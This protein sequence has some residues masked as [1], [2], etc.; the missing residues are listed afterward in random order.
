MR[1]GMTVDGKACT[2]DVA[3][4]HLLAEWLRAIGKT[5]V[6][7]GC[8][9]STCGA[10]TV[11]LDGSA[12]KSCTLFTVQADGRRVETIHGLTPAAGL[13]PIQESFVAEHGTQCGF[14]TPGFI[15]AATAL[16][17]ENANP[18]RADILEALEGNLCRCTGYISIIRAVEHAAAAMREEPIEPRA[19]AGHEFPVEPSSVV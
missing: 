1:F 14:C 18:T 16:L 19:G 2:G 10:C 4:R 15:V 12:V 6:H 3:P 17:R 9:T 13:S 5:G 7:I 11:L 8:D